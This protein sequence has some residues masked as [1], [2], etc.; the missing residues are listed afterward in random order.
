MLVIPAQAGIHLDL[1]PGLIW[2]RTG[3]EQQ[4]MDPG[5]TSFAVEGRWDDGQKQIEATAASRLGWL[6]STAHPTT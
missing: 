6:K 2:I 4:Q 1:V 5:L 3:Q